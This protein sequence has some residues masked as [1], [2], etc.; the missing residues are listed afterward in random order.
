MIK[1]TSL[2]LCCV[3]Y[4]SIAYG[5][6]LPSNESFQVVNPMRIT[7]ALSGNFGELR[8]NHFHA[9]IDLKTGGQ[10]GLDILAIEDGY[11][12]R[13]KI[14][15]YGYGKVLYI[16]HPNGYTSVYAHLSGFEQSI[17]AYIKEQQFALKSADVD[18]FP[19]KNLLPVKQGELVAYSGNTGG[20]A[21]PHLHFEIR[22]TKSEIPRNPLLL[23]FPIQ[24]T[25]PPII[26]AI[27]VVPLSETSKVNGAKTTFRS[28]VNGSNLIAQQPIKIQGDFG[29]QVRGYDSQDG[30]SNQNGIFKIEWFVDGELIGYFKADSIPFDLSRH[31]N[32]LI[33]YPYYYYN[34]G[35]YLKLYRSPGNMLP[36]LKYPANG[37]M[38]LKNGQHKLTIVASDVHQNRT[39]LDFEV[40]VEATPAA[41]HSVKNTD[42]ELLR[43]DLPYF[44]ES[45][46]FKIFMP[47]L[48]VYEN[49]ALKINELK[50]AIPSIE[51]MNPS[52]PVQEAF[53]IQTP[54]PA[55]AA[56][57]TGWFIAQLD[58]NGKPIR[59][60]STKLSQGWLSAESK[61]FGRFGPY[62]DVFAPG[63]K[64]VNFITGNRYKEG[65]IKFNVS[66]ALSGIE[67]IEVF[68]NN[69]WMRYDYEP[70]QD[71]LTIDVTDIEKSPEIQ[72][73]ML[74]VTDLA[75]NVA[76]FEGKFIRE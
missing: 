3:F 68:I 73:I 17:A 31:M 22:E 1:A 27:A 29:L 5:Q 14:S 49:E 41:A 58:A 24:D 25:K 48:C 6:S 2:I 39:K 18:L 59:A 67:K 10:E 72:E 43:W 11:V 69:E 36:N 35:R 32:A 65:L 70:K 51:V 52:I 23:N 53:V 61:S 8:P 34:K 33:D 45:E 64:S 37:I 60:L 74:K 12:S 15:P 66:D 71:L 26:E 46:A 13:I 19:A 7:P 20:S 54:I 44:Y 38:R 40:V 57:K 28:R 30:S 4:F 75:G 47:R 50:G 21:G 55:T 76:T 63:I 16:D 56:S 9:G 62:Q 42:E